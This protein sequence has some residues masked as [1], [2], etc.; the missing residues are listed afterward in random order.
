[1]KTSRARAV[2]WGVHLMQASVQTDGVKQA[3][4]LAA[5]E[6]SGSRQACQRDRTILSRTL[7][8]ATHLATGPAMAY[9]L[10]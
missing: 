1:M 4:Q 2:Y 9:T 8:A 3:K 6:A 7:C 10:P 5:Q